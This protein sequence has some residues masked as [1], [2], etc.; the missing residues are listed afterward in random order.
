MNKGRYGYR[1][2]TQTLRNEGYV[3]SEKTVR[4][5]M[6]ESGIKCM[7]RVK[8]YRSYKGE[9]GRIAP[10]L[11]AR[12]FNADSPCQKLVTDVT[13]FSLFGTKLYLS[14]VLDLYNS[15][16]IYY[17]IYDHPVLDMVTDM[18][19]GMIS[20]I[21]SDTNAILHSDQG[22]QYQ[23][24]RYQEML[25]ENNIHQS[26]SRKGNCLDNSVI[27]NFFGLLKSE[28]LYLQKF[29]SVEDFKE[30]LKRYLHY[31]NFDRI[32]LKLNGMSPVQYRVHNT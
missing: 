9:V 29:K 22:W 30:E 15:E 23:H 25:K 13:E 12:N 14:P 6:K 32:K 28:L 31:Y 7:V 21:G 20:V 19:K 16:L 11:L 24:K 2:I 26:M 4:K 3:I 10:N 8:K 1:R 18:V 27:E 17:T 5:L